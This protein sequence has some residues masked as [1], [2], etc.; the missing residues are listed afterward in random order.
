MK[1]IMDFKNCVQDDP[2]ESSRETSIKM[3]DPDKKKCKHDTLSQMFHHTFD[4]RQDEDKSVQDCMKQFEAVQDNLKNVVGK[5]ILH[6]FAKSTKRHKDRN[7]TEQ[8]ELQDM[9]FA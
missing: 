7:S 2:V 9:L 3:C 6:E 8:K 1:K 4:T 5:K